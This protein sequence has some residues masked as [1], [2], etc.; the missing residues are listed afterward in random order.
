MEIFSQSLKRLR[1]F[2]DLE[3]KGLSVMPIVLKNQ[4]LDDQIISEFEE[5]LTWLRE[6]IEVK[7]VCLIFHIDKTSI[8]KFNGEKEYLSYRS[9]CKKLFEKLEQL[10]QIIISDFKGSF[11]SAWCEFTYHS[12][13]CISHQESK[14][15]WNHLKHGV[16]PF[17]SSTKK[18]GRSLENIILTSQTV[19]PHKLCDINT[20]AQTYCDDQ[21]RRNLLNTIKQNVLESSPTSIIQLKHAFQE[22]KQ[23]NFDHVVHYTYLNSDWMN[24]KE[25][26]TVHEM[27]NIL[28]KT[29]EQQ[30]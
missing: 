17:S 5:I 12:N 15:L 16:L 21:E 30:Q 9:K 7:F 20:I 11:E 1:A 10:P 19:T 13:F 26:S 22:E 2:L 29:I 18:I 27:K 8:P 14:F 4:E 6:H 24:Q 3:Y 23:D 28:K 25:F